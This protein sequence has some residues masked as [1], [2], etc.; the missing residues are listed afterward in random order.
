MELDKAET[1]FG[2]MLEAYKIGGPFMHII[3][4]LG[5]LMLAITV[6]KVV[7]IFT[8]KVNNLKFLDLILM[9]GSVSLAVG[10][11]SQIVGIVQALEVIRAAADISPQIVMG[12]AIVS[13]Y[14]PIWGFVV[15]IFSMI[16]Y[17]VLK[18]I[19]KPRLPE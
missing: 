12:G 2:Y 11:L 16:S 18:E 3:T 14:A 6:W 15:F 13:F 5:L 19:I 4:L 10:L 7:E 9:A 8:K 17:F 1:G